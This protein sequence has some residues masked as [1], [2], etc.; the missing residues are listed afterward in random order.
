MVRPVPCGDLS[1]LRE[2]PWNHFNRF[3]Q[4]PSG[5]RMALKVTNHRH[6]IDQLIKRLDRLDPI[7]GFLPELRDGFRDKFA[8]DS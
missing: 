5:Y 4:A 3:D 6:G 7:I 2:I 1:K 8:D